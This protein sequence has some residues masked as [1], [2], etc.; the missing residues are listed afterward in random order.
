VASVKSAPTVLLT[1]E[2]AALPSMTKRKNHQYSDREAV[3]EKSAYLAK[4]TLIDSWNVMPASHET[5]EAIDRAMGRT[6]TKS[7]PFA[8]VDNDRI[9]CSITCAAP[10]GR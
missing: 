7:R 3:P 8:R 5:A 2:A 6:A 10:S 1:I 9:D 4:Q